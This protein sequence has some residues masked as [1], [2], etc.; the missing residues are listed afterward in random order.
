MEVVSPA[1]GKGHTRR[2]GQDTT[3]GKEF[4]RH[5]QERRINALFD[6]WT[7]YLGEL[8][9]FIIGAFYVQIGGNIILRLL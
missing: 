5:S 9:G 7:G 3:Q 2:S 1:N 4:L 8:F 6:E